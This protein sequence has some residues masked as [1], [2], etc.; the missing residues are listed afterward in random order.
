MET[1]VASKLDLQITDAGDDA[2]NSFATR[3]KPSDVKRICNAFQP[4]Q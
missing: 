3:S 4:R 2:L 1:L